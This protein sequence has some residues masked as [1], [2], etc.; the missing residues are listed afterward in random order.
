MGTVLRIVDSS[1][2]RYFKVRL[3]VDPSPGDA[4]APIAVC[5]VGPDPRGER[6]YGIINRSELE[7][8]SLN[9]ALKL[10]QKNITSR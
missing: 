9:T 1:V 8:Q 5:R 3:H 2:D 7:V 10:T 6:L 4:D